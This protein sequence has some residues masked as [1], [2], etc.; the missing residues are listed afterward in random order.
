MRTQKMTAKG[1][2]CWCTLPSLGSIIELFR[3]GSRVYYG[4]VLLLC[5]AGLGLFIASVSILESDD[6]TGGYLLVAM[7]VCAALEVL[8]LLIA[9]PV[10]AGSRFFIVR[11]LNMS[12]L[13]P[14]VGCASYMVVLLPC[15]RADDGARHRAGVRG[16][17]VD[18]GGVV[19]PLPLDHVFWRR[20]RDL[21]CH[22]FSGPI[23]GPSQSAHVDLTL[24]SETS[25][26]WF[27]CRNSAYFACVQA[28][29]SRAFENDG[30]VVSRVPRLNVHVGA[31]ASVDIASWR[32]AGVR[33]LVC[34]RAHVACFAYA[35]TSVQRFV[36]LDAAVC[37]RD[38]VHDK[39]IHLPP[40]V[41]TRPRAHV[42]VPTSR[43][44]LLIMDCA[45]STAVYSTLPVVWHAMAW[46]VA[47]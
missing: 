6:T 32:V 1:R 4:L 37:E 34:V 47:G 42:S 36:L 24:R 5:F 33:C 44:D 14:F 15:L 13:L 31:P 17:D 41:C 3:R 12:A 10:G 45:G 35:G 19:R 11:G 39:P 38:G 43:N 7:L 23:S 2:S 29:A 26:V 28:M 21:D 27:H 25:H 20:I 30:D 22:C 9:T 16:R 40:Q 8:I 18:R 46:P